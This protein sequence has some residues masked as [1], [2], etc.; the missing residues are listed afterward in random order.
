MPWNSSAPD[1]VLGESV[2]RTLRVAA[3]GVGSLFVLLAVLGGS[4]SGQIGPFR[5]AMLL[6]GLVLVTVAAAIHA[7]REELLLSVLGVTLAFVTLVFVGVGGFDLTEIRWR[8]WKATTSVLGPPEVGI[9]APSDTFGY[10][11]RAHAVGRHRHFDFDVQYSIDADG[12]R[13]TPTPAEH[14]GE[15]LFLGG[16]FT[17]GHGVNDH[18]AY[19]AVLADQFWPTHKVR[20]RAV[21]GWGTVHAYLALQEEL[22]KS[23]KP[24]A[25]VY[26]WFDEHV[27]RNYLRKSWLFSLGR[28][29]REHPHVEIE[30]GGIVL[31]GVVGV[32]AGLEESAEFDA[33][34]EHVTDS[35]L[36]GMARLSRE[37]KV[38][39]FVVLLER[40][41]PIERARQ[42]VLTAVEE[43]GIS[44][45]DATGVNGDF[46]PHDRHPTAGWHQAVAELI[47]SSQVSAVLKR[48][49]AP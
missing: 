30:N 35:L 10:A 42:I 47:A 16:S 15:I 23:P 8:L 25:V 12:S 45:I 9:W 5:V 41:A 19:P 44:M 49:E 26:G 7:R 28:Y 3:F 33:V 29:G 37:H 18:E 31:K 39:F 34:E 11:H 27:R 38:P 24:S 14:R 17:F 46:F 43:E 6:S 2:L 40:H 32:E 22:W 36:R 48:P 1:P 20:N 4:S 21:M 13:I